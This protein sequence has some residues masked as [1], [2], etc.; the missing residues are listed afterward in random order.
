MVD[1]HIHV[2]E[3]ATRNSRHSIFA[4]PKRYQGRHLPGSALPQQLP[5]LKYLVRR[6][7]ILFP[8]VAMVTA[9]SLP[10]TRE[11]TVNTVTGPGAG[12]VSL[13]PL[14]EGPCWHSPWGSMVSPLQKKENNRQVQLASNLK[15][16]AL[17]IFLARPRDTR[18][19]E[20]L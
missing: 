8:K 1:E 9:G 11:A 5:G 7:W 13:G 10:V 4:V 14:S 15:V 16:F 3:R 2:C 20:A 19:N 12:G 17:F 18:C 6:P